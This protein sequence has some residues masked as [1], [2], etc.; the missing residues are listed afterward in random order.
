MLVWASMVENMPT[1]KEVTRAGKSVI[2]AGKTKVRA[3]MGGMA[4]N[5][6]GSK[7]VGSNMHH[8][9]QKF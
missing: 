7:K 4:T 1:G 8:R 3:G 2:R 9:S 5:G 6:S